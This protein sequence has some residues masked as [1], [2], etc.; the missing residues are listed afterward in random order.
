MNKYINESSKAKQ[1]FASQQTHKGSQTTPAAVTPTHK[2]IARRAYE[3]YIENGRRQGQSEQYWLQ[4][5]Q[6][7][8][9]RK[10]WRQAE[11]Q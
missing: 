8:K 6:E 9:N 1:A 2:E 4:A 3:I 7:L 10:H 5:E 11:E